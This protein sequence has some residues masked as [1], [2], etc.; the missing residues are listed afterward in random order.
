MPLYDQRRVWRV[1]DDGTSLE[2]ADA[3]AV[4]Y[5][6]NTVRFSNDLIS[7]SS[8][9]GSLSGNEAIVFEMLSIPILT[10]GDLPIGG[11]WLNKSNTIVN[12][13]SQNG[14][15]VPGPGNN[16]DTLIRPALNLVTFDGNFS[17]ELQAIGT[18]VLTDSVYIAGLEFRNMNAT[19]N[20]CAIKSMVKI[21]L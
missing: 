4:E 6:P 5:T 20:S 18:G 13:F 8:S 3:G 2:F 17:T 14:S 15:R 21:P 12:G 9:L 11:L 10:S 1:M 16:V 7:I 19:T